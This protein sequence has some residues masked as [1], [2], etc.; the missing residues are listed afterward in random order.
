MKS[1]RE[2]LVDLVKV[3]NNAL[4]IAQHGGH[5][6]GVA[7]TAVLIGPL[8]EAEKAIANEQTNRSSVPS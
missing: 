4:D 6:T 5:I 1:Q 7:L 2:A 8:Q 3:V